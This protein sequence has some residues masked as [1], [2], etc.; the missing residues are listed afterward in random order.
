[1][2]SPDRAGGSV[3][4]SRDSACGSC[5]WRSEAR[6]WACGGAAARERAIWWSGG[7]L[8]RHPIRRKA[9]AAI[10]EEMAEAL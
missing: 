9:A 3:G 5:D 2:R 8:R 4:D 10:L 7:R 1:M 6:G